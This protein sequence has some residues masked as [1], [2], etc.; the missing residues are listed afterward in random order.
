VGFGHL[1]D[2]A[3]SEKLSITER[4]GNEDTTETTHDQDASIMASQEEESLFVYISQQL[5]F[6]KFDCSFGDN[7]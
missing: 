3:Y 4:P 1:N 7:N 5:G 6:P 2:I